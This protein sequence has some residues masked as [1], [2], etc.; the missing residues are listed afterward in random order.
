MIAEEA[1]ERVD[2]D[3]IE[4]RGLGRVSTGTEDSAK[5]GI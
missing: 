3:D 5:V 2:D 4:R 1:A